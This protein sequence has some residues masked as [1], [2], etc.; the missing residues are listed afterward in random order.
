MVIER[1]WMETLKMDESGPNMK[2]KKYKLANKF[3]FYFSFIYYAIPLLIQWESKKFE[4]PHGK[5][6]ELNF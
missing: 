3:V 6:E 1:R 5:E 4:K 2:S